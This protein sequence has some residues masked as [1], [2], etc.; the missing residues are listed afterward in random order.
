MAARACRI[1]DCPVPPGIRP[2]QLG[3]TA[4]VRDP[5]PAG[6]PNRLTLLS[7]GIGLWPIRA[8]LAASGQANLTAGKTLRCGFWRIPRSR[9]GQ[10]NGIARQESLRVPSQT[11][12]Q[13]Q[14]RG[15]ETGRPEGSSGADNQLTI[16]SN[17]QNFVQPRLGNRSA[18]VSE[19][20][21]KRDWS[22]N[23][24]ASSTET[25]LIGGG[26]LSATTNPLRS[27]VYGRA[28]EQDRAGPTGRTPQDVVAKGPLEDGSRP[29][30]TP[31]CPPGTSR[32][33]RGGFHLETQ[34]DG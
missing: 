14:C 21:Y 7:R 22:A 5:L 17:R 33:E 9:S 8:V 34:Q 15:G 10:I 30:E 23:A 28:G 25:S 16:D 11:R 20:L 29:R 6:P 27:P 12:N 19:G 18:V 3:R 26:I 1:N 24:V 4:R 32:A 2:C 13:R 31:Y